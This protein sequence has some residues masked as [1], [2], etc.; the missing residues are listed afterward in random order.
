MDKTGKYVYTTEIVQAQT[1]KQPKF[2]LIRK[3][4]IHIFCKFNLQEKFFLVY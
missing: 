3:S 4:L 1:D 2:F